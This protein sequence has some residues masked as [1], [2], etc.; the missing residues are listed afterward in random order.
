MKKLLSLLL[1]LTALITLCGCNFTAG[2]PAEKAFSSNGMTITLTDAFKETTAEGYTVAYDSETVAVFAIKESFTLAEG[3]QDWTLE[4][5][6]ERVREANSEHAP[7]KI[8]KE[9][10]RYCFN[11]NWENPET[12][13]LYYYYTCMYKGSD[14]FWVVQF[15]C[16]ITD[17]PSCATQMI[18]W[19]NSVKV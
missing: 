16:K 13:V 9:N 14:A 12:D 4:D 19:A 7:T 3:M 10:D 6:A 8:Q 2:A 11:Y 15:S 17:Y 5:Y 18:M 1:A